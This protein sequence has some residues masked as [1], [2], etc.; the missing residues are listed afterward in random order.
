MWS[1]A[2]RQEAGRCQH[3]GDDSGVCHSL[4]CLRCG[5]TV[6]SRRAAPVSPLSP[7]YPYKHRALGRWCGPLRPL[8][9]PR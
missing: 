8:L 1:A 5:G 4:R 7:F 9:L 3:C 6:C 2:R